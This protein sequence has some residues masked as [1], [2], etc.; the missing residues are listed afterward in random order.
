M[1]TYAITITF[2][3]GST[4]DV[5]WEDYDS[6]KAIADVAMRLANVSSELESPVISIALADF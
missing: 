5:L 1:T 2:R 3:D 6:C 4:R